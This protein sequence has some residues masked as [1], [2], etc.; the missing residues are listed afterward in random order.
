MDLAEPRALDE[1]ERLV[2]D[3]LLSWDFP[4]VVVLRTQIEGA[5]VVGS[6]D[7]GC[8]T[9]YLTVNQSLQRTTTLYT[10]EIIPVAGHFDSSDGHKF[11]I[12]VVVK[13]GS[14]A[15]LRVW[16]LSPLPAQWPPPQLIELRVSS[17]T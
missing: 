8:A 9:I 4:E 1:S 16:G 2:L 12:T 6:C 15:M 13:G 5:Q 14:L 11:G 10:D 17:L 3:H 7:C